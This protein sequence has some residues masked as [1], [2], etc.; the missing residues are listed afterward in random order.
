MQKFIQLTERDGNKIG[1]SVDHIITYKN[2]I[3]QTGSS[4]VSYVTGLHIKD[5]GRIYVE[6]TYGTV[7]RLIQEACDA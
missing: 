6:E 3:V 4:E 1:I 2:T 7:K 5:S